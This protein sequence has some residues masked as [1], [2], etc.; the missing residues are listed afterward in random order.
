MS[1]E[2]LNGKRV[3]VMQTSPQIAHLKKQS[4]RTGLT[5]SDLVRRAVDAMIHRTEEKQRDKV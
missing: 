2:S 4:K 1:R 3:H 5:T